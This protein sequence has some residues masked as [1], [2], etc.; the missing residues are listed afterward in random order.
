MRRLALAAAL[1]VPAG[2]FAAPAVASSRVAASQDVAT[3]QSAQVV[4]AAPGDS[5]RT[6]A[7]VHATRPITGVH[8]SLP[9]VGH[10]SDA[11]GHIWLHVRLP[12]RV[13]GQPA[14]PA[15]AWLRADRAR[16]SAT[17]WHIVVQ[18]AARRV[19]VY[20]D[21][22]RV[23]SFP[24]AVGKLSTPTPR[25]EFFVEENV[26]MPASAAGAPFALA[27]SARSNVLQE[28]EGGPGQIAL[29]GRRNI[30]GALGSAI[31]HGCVR[32][33]DS[34]ISWLARQ[35]VPGTPVTIE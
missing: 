4:S 29:H 15:T 27:T 21:G 35:A 33:A 28:F 23:R 22:A 24:A 7:V 34:S 32:L 10:R 26:R 11:R 14:P 8:T 25:G 31:S 12:G 20:R 17:P 19:L 9:V 5:A 30:G 6:V 1:I 18:R 2:A 3:L 16:L 13:L